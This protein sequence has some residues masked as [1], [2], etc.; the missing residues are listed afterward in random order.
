[1][2]HL[3]YFKDASVSSFVVYFNLLFLQ[4]T[5]SLAWLIA[6][7]CFMMKLLR[8]AVMITRL[9]D[10]LIVD[11]ADEHVRLFD[12]QTSFNSLKLDHHPQ[13]YRVF[14][15]INVVNPS[16]LHSLVKLLLC[17]S[18]LILLLP[19]SPILYLFPQLVH[20]EALMKFHYYVL[21]FNDSS[22]VLSFSNKFFA[23]TKAFH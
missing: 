1:M 4:T 21:I 19:F 15:I 7:R 11:H 16:W 3:S 6:V 13:H 18:K 10:C 9:V 17:F 8:Q 22:K 2:T 14:L 20:F 5:F 12:W 23:W